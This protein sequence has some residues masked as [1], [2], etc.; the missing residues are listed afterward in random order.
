MPC[1]SKE[2]MLTMKMACIVL[3]YNDAEMTCKAVEVARVTNENECIIVVDNCSRDQDYNKLIGIQDK[4]TLL[5]RSNKN[6]G[7]GSGNNLGLRKAIEMGMTHAVIAN[8]DVSY[9]A[10][11]IAEMKKVF[12]DKK[13]CGVV[14]PKLDYRGNLCFSKLPNAKEILL[15]SSSL[16]LKLFGRATAY[17][18]EYYAQKDIVE[19]EVVVGAMLAVDLQKMK[20]CFYDERFFLYGEEWVLGYKMREHGY[21]TYGLLNVGYS[22]M[23]SHTIDQEYS[24]FSKRRK[25]SNNSKKLYL[26]YYLKVSK[27]YYCFADFILWILLFE[28]KVIELNRKLKK[29]YAV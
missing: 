29:L 5:L 16:Y 1:N 11:C 4:H 27:L 23:L 6:G 2:E 10:A 28:A 17:P 26:K 9:S 13:D 15:E 20:D 19:C 25:L 8:P 12:L 24:G 18:K 7:Y 3:N 21:K 22:H 14:A